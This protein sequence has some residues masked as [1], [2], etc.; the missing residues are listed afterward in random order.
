ML[1]II[2][3][4]QGRFSPLLRHHVDH[5]ARDDDD[6]AHLEEHAEAI[7][8]ELSAEIMRVN[9]GLTFEIGPLKDSRREF[10][11]SADGIRQ[12]FPAVQALV[13]AAPPMPGWT[14][15]AFRQP[16][17]SMDWVIQLEDCQLE[18]G[19]V[20]FSAAPEGK[21]VALQLYVRGFQ[22]ESRQ[23]LGKAT[24][25]LLDCALGEYAVETG[26]GTVE[27]HLLPE[28]PAALGLQPF[29]A[30]RDAVR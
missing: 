30:I 13:G 15:V 6:L 14:V 1:K 25:L 28:D 11:V 24:F 9:K 3:R 26:I 5:L 19:D 29:A 20:W 8:H 7:F 10:V 18:A 22:D 16:K 23:T 2:I 4:R 12:F 27:F 21:R 17:E